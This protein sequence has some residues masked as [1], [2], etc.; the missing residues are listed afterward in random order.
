MHGRFD[1]KGNNDDSADRNSGVGFLALPLLLVIVL[2]TLAI[3][4]PTASTWISEALQAEFAG[5]VPVPSMDP[6][7][8]IAQP[9]MEIR[10]VDA[11]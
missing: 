5:E 6:P 2:V 9:A 10:T 11:Y 3:I 4:Q 8:Q 7:T 1:E